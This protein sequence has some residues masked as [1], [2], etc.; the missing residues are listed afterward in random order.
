MS[1]CPTTQSGYAINT[2]MRVILTIDPTDRTDIAMRDEAV[3]WLHCTTRNAWSVTE[4]EDEGDDDEQ[5]M[6]LTFEFRDPLDADDFRY[7]R[8]LRGRGR[9]S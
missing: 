3:D 1:H 7:W 6:T 4:V 5:G 9:L 2:A 8:G